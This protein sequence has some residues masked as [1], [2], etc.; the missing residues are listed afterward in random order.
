ME[1]MR[2]DS[3]VKKTLQDYLARAFKMKNLNLLKHFY[4]IKV[5]QYYKGIV[6]S[7]KNIV[8]HLR[9]KTSILAFQLVD[10][11]IK[12]TLKLYIESNKYWLTKKDTE[13]L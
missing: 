4:E 2:N 11:P 6:L 12:E 1:V 10:T 7:K 5:S 3:K 8:D 13:N 9:K